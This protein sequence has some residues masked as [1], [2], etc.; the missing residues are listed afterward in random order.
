MKTIGIHRDPLTDE[1]YRIVRF[2]DEGPAYGL[3]V[4]RCDDDGIWRNV[5]TVP[6]GAIIRE[7]L[8]IRRSVDA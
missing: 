2:H 7:A 3:T 6:M 4:E 1:A 5:A 8:R